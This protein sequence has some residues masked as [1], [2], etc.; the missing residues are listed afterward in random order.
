MT[1]FVLLHKHE[2]VYRNGTT[3]VPDENEGFGNM[4]SSFVTSFAMMVGEVDYRDIFLQQTGKNF[5]LIQLFLVLF[6]II[7]SILLMNLLT[8]LAVGDIDVIMKRSLAEKRIQRVRV[9]DVFQ[10]FLC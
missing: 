10:S 3:H 2:N 4:A 5:A 1:F 9:S 8:G 7:M 6:L